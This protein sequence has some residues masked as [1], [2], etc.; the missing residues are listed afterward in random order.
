[1][2]R[3]QIDYLK[4]KYPPGTRIM[5]DHMG[6]DPLPIE[7]GTMGTVKMVD[8][9]GSLHC[10]FDNGR[11]LGVCPEVDSFHKIAQQEESVAQSNPTL[12]M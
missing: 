8:N 11:C 10:Q 7:S 9:M 2:N 12:S 5:L 1:M 6:D 3:S 4:L